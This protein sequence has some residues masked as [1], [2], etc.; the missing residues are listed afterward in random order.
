MSTA[1]QIDQTSYRHLMSNLEA[2]PRRVGIRVFRIA[3]NAWGGVVKAAE[4]SYARQGPSDLIPKAIVVEVTIPDASYNIK[5]HGKPATVAVGVSRRFVR[6]GTSGGSGFKGLS[7]RKREAAR[8]A[9][10]RI[11]ARRPSRYAHFVEKGI[12][13][14]KRIVPHAFVAPAARVGQT[15]GFQRFSTKMAEGIQTEA[16]KLPK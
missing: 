5:H 16:A 14:R 7:P 3:L 8:S 11:Q 10:R 6:A 12:A 15:A 2:L 1:L 4:I 9:G 13:G